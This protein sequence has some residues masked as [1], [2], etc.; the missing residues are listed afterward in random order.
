[1]TLALCQPHFPPQNIRND[2]SL[3]RFHSTKRK[4]FFMYLPSVGLMGGGGG[5]EGAVILNVSS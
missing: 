2:D 3:I 1:M 5:E 4:H